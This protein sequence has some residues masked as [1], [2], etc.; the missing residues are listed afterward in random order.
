M[1]DKLQY[2][3]RNLSYPDAVGQIAEEATELAHAALKLE[4][5]VRGTN[6]TPVTVP[7]A[8]NKVIEEIADVLNAMEVLQFYPDMDSIV[9]V[10]YEKMDRWIERLKEKEAEVQ[11][12]H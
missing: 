8:I 7:E 6:P 11:H 3:R 10:R 5:A 9:K 1:E 2:I 12:G 4:R